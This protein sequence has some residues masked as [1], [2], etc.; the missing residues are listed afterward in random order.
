MTQYAVRGYYHPEHSFA[1][2]NEWEDVARQFLQLQKQGADTRGGVIDSNPKLIELINKWFG[3]QLYVETQRFDQLTQKNV[4][5]FIEDFVNH[6]VWGLRKEF[7]SYF[8]SESKDLNFIDDI[9]VGYFYSRGDIEPYVLL[10]DAFTSNVYGTTNHIVTTLHW[11]SMQGMKNLVDSIENKMQFDISTF[12]KQ[13]KTFFQPESNYL[14]KLQG[15]LVAAFK[16]DVKSIVTDHG[17]KAANMYRLAFPGENPNLCQSIQLCND[18]DDS[19]S[20]WNEIIVQ[21]TKIISYKKVNKY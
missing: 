13:W 21:P 16:S 20:L 5:D 8:H 11:T 18:D 19:T 4:L 6:K 15:K 1:T 7:N 2:I 14:V 17:N 3:Y 12:T 10:D 9:K